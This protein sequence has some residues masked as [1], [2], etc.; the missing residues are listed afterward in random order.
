MS[1][2]GGCVD[3][4]V[5][6]DSG[7]VY[8]QQ[9]GH[10]DAGVDR[11]QAYRQGA[12]VSTWVSTGGRHIDKGWVYQQG[13]GISTGDRRINSRAGVSTAGGRVDSRVGV[14][15]GWA[16]RQQGGH[17]NAGVDRRRA[18]RQGAGVSRGGRCIYNRVG[19]S[20][21]GDVCINYR[22][23]TNLCI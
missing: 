15:R 2:A 6:V 9:G 11:R 13:V 22:V 19:V 7:R 1:T 8:Q 12:G 5:G 20:T 10:I 23:G 3:S 18:Y 14:D 17:I 16:Y 4:R 21:G